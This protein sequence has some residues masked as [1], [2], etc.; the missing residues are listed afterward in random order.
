MFLVAVISIKTI[1][2]QI[3]LVPCWILSNRGEV[4]WTFFN[5]LW[6]VDQKRGELFYHLVG[7]SFYAST[8]PT[9]RWSTIHVGKNGYVKASDVK[10]IDIG[11]KLTPS[12]TPEEAKVASLKK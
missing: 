4:Q 1:I 7:T 8:T 6:S 3:K 11:L 2:G 9:A 10:S 5:S 12:N